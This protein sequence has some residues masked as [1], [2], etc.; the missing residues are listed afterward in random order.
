MDDGK[1]RERVRR[2][3]ITGEMDS[4]AL[5]AFHLEARRLARNFGLDVKKVRTEKPR[6]KRRAKR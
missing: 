3:E 6:E 4:H 5:E 1:V 2:L